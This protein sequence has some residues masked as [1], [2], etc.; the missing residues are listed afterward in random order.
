MPAQNG[1]FV[2]VEMTVETSAKLAEEINPL[3]LLGEGVGKAIAPDGTTSNAQLAT[4]AALSCFDKAEVLPSMIG[5]GEKA[6]GEVVLDVEDSRGILVL[7][8]T[9]VALVMGAS[10]AIHK[11]HEQPA[12][13]AT[14]PK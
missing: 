11:R 3:F 8:Y 14:E 2:T 4:G 7:D 12:L 1:T 9:Q 13:P 6:T 10:G 5:P